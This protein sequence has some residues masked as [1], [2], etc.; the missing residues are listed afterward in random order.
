MLEEYLNNIS[1]KDSQNC[2]DKNDY[3]FLKAN[4]EMNIFSAISEIAMKIF[5]LLSLNVKS[6]TLI[7]NI[8]LV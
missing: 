5:F 8:L 3:D 7:I 4:K 1:I 6:F 2:M